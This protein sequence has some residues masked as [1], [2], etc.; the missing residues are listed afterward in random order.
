M[1]GR[2]ANRRSCLQPSKV[3]MMNVPELKTR[4]PTGRPAWP[5]VLLEGEEKAGKTYAALSL[6]ADARVGRTFVIDAGE[7]SADGYATLG[8]FEIVEHDHTFNSIAAQLAAVRSVPC[9]PDRP[10]VLVIDTVSYLWQ[11]LVDQAGQRARAS[12]AG[13]RR[14]AADPDAEIP[15]SMNLWA[16]AK[17]RWRSMLDPLMTYPGIVVLIA[18]GRPVAEV[19]PNGAPTGAMGWKVEAEKNLA[20]DATVWV[21]MTRPRTAQLLGARSLT[22]TVPEHRPLPLADFTLAGLLFDQ[23]GLDPA[24]TAVR[25][26]E[27]LAADA[28]AANDAKR[29]LIDHLTGHGCADPVATARACWHAAGYE[30]RAELTPAELTDL[31]AGAATAAEVAR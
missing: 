30:D 29:Q 11:L 22:L 31:L 8:E 13:Q 12:K 24:Q 3:L 1:A 17:R 2:D 19:D 5:L 20:Y 6:S 9:D 23:L 16:D 14:L 27:P 21:R 7:G 10:N 4:K 28:V 25:D 15:I 26:Y 18:R